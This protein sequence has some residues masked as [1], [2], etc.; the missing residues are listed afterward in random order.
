MRSLGAVA[1]AIWLIFI[2]V[3]KCSGKLP[4]A[5]WNPDN[6]KVNLNDNNADNS[7]ENLGVRFLVRELFLLEGFPPATK[8]TADLGKVGLCLE[9]LCF[10]DELQLKQE[11]EFQ[12]NNFNKTGS[13]V[14]SYR[15]L[16]GKY[17]SNSKR[18]I[19]DWQV[20]ELFN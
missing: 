3:T 16:V 10:I 14:S 7:N 8:H 5:N 6:R 2:E 9:N 18:E 4:N 13:F 17:S 1:T 15:N 11:A 20:N 12:D 19:F